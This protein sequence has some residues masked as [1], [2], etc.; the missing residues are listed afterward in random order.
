MKTIIISISM[1]LLSATT[2]N[3]HIGVTIAKI[4]C[5]SYVGYSI[6]SKE[7]QRQMQCS[8][9]QQIQATSHLQK[10]HKVNVTSGVVVKPMVIQPSLPLN[11]VK[12]IQKTK[13]PFPKSQ[14]QVISQ[15]AL[16]DS[17]SSKESK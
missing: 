8:T 9:Q 5:R 6:Q 3:A 10:G 16:P 13:N 1:L 15:R 2:S 17:I 11:L 7:I 12:Q 4:A 14:I